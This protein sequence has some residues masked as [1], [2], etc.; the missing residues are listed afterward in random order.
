MGGNARLRQVVSQ[1]SAY[2][3]PWSN[4]NRLA[5]IMFITVWFLTCRFTPNP[6]N[7]WR[8]F[9]LRL[10]RTTIRGRPYV[11]PSARITMPWNVTLEHRAAVGPGVE[12]YALGKII[13]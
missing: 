7:L 10:F 13:L 8:L 2:E 9:V 12:L 5:R 11:A 4:S 6:L 1:E 3:S